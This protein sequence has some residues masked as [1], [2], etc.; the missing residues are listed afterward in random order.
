MALWTF[1]GLLKGPAT[2]GWPLRGDADGQAGVLGMPRYHPEL[3]TD[4][5]NDCT[6]VC[7]TE[8]ITLRRDGATRLEVDYGRCV[9]CQ[10]CTEACPTGAMSPSEDWAFGVRRREDLV[11]A[12]AATG[13]TPAPEPRTAGVP[14]QSAHPPCRCGFLQR[15][16]VRAAG[17]EQSVLQSAPAGHLLYSVAALRR[18]VAGDRA[19]DAR[20]AGAAARHVRSDA[21]AALGDRGRHLRGVGRGCRRRLRVRPRPGWGSAG[22]CVF[23]GLP[24]KPGGDHRGAANVSRSDA[25]ARPGRPPWP[26]TSSLPRRSCGYWAARSH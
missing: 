20:D 11:W 8:A 18:P 19:G 16:R 14:P 12:D 6:A 5:C 23:A 26:M 21:G 7:P 10:L 24:A 3:C 4:G 9:V 2:T 17:A 22:R 1:F 25:A 13:V 15:L